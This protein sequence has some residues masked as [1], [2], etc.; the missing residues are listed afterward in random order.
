MSHQDEHLPEE[1]DELSQDDEKAP[2][3][4][5][6]KVPLSAVGSR[7]DVMHDEKVDEK[8]EELEETHAED[9]AVVKK[10]CKTSSTQD[11]GCCAKCCKCLANVP[12]GSLLCFVFIIAMVS[13]CAGALMVALKRTREVLDNDNIVP[14]SNALC[15][16]VLFGMVFLVTLFLVVAALSSPPTSSGVFSTANKNTCARALNIIVLVLLI[17]LV[18]A[19]TLV[20]IV[21]ALPVIYI[22]L[23][24]ILHTTDKAACVDLWNYG[25]S[26]VRNEMCGAT[27]EDF[28]ERVFVR[29]DIMVCYSISIIAAVLVIVLLV[30]FIVCTTA[31]YIQLRTARDSKYQPHTDEVNSA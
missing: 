9:V 25:L 1:Q 31:N 24:H 23:F 3:A 13:T 27:L 26:S 20:A 30:L 6:E 8:G 19:W 2:L 10:S 18:F 5:E 15:L 17:F 7:D 11:D 12:C 4:D 21:L 14:M 22:V 29:D 28:Y 16:G